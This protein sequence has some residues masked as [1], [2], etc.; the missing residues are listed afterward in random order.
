LTGLT[1]P[2]HI[3]LITSIFALYYFEM[4]NN[5]YGNPY[6][7]S[8]LSRTMAIITIITEAMAIM[9]QRGATMETRAITTILINNSL[10]MDSLIMDLMAPLMVNT[11]KINTPIATKQT[12]T[13][14]IAV[15]ALEQ[16]VALVASYRPV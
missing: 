12:K 16:P 3:C 1:L 2:N 11:V 5:P 13:R 7:P 8:Q 15:H 10:I 9:Q 4:N 6:V 14:L